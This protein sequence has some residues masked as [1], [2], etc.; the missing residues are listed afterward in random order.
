VLIDAPCSGIG[1]W[2]R[3]PHARWTS[4]L[5]DVKELAAVQTTLLNHVA[6]ALKK[7]GR[8]IYS[9]CTLTRA[10]TTAIAD[11]FTAAHPEF[12]PWPVSGAEPS[13]LGAQHFLWPQ[14]LNANGMFIATWKRK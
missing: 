2:Q 4:S 14:A 9:V 6:P 13:A 1:T 12:E 5:T 11:A 10:E 3:N 7:G 8:L